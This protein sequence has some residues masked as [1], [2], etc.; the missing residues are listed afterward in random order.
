MKRSKKILIVDDDPE[1]RLALQHILS[2]LGHKS[3]CANNG[4]MA[5]D[6]LSHAEKP[7]MIFCDIMMPKMN[8]LEFLSKL[9]TD[10]HHSLASIPVVILSSEKEMSSEVASYG[11]Y[12]LNKTF[13]VDELVSLVNR[14]CA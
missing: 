9:K 3:F 4:Q 7:S 11:A 13:N 1:M 5:L 6:I 2:I 14:Y 12:F 10:T 8:G